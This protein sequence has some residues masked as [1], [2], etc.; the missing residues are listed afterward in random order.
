[1]PLVRKVFEIGNS[2][3]I[4]LPKSWFAFHEK[5]TGQKIAE[6]AIE[7][8]GILRVEPILEKK[9]GDSQ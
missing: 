4:T 2:K 1:M 7:V 5:E 6:V 9:K 3:A 8:D